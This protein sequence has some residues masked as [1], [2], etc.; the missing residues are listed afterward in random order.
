LFYPGLQKDVASFVG[1]PAGAIPATGTF[2]AKYSG[3]RENQANKKSREY[4]SN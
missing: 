1:G 2:F 3:S 4:G